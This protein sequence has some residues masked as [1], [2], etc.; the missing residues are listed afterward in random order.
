MIARVTSGWLRQA[1]CT[2][3]KCSA[4]FPIRATT[5]TPTKNSL[6]PSCSVTG[7]ITATRAS[8]TTAAPTVARARTVIA[9]CRLQTGPSSGAVAS[10]I[11]P[12]CASS[13]FPCPR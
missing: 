3:L 8:L 9:R 2:A 13:G 6:Q 10:T 7:S 12:I 11:G 4:V 5:I 1:N